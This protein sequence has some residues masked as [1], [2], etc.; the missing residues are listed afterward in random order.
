M[1]H[2][3]IQGGEQYL[4]FARSRITAM[5]AT[6]LRYASQKF[7]VDGTSI[8]VQ[9]V[10]EHEYIRLNGGDISILS[11]VVK[12]G[13]LVELPVPE[14]SPPG[15]TPVTTLR[16]FRA[17]PQCSQYAKGGSATVFHDMD[18]L[19]VEAHADMGISG[20]QYTDLCA[21]MYS[22][23]M[24]KVVQIIMGYGK[25]KGS[26]LTGV[27]VKYDFRWA[28]CHGVVTG[29][30]GKKWLLEISSANGVMAMRLPLSR[31]GST[32][33]K[34][35]VIKKTR[36]LL[37]GFPTGETFPVGAALTAAIAA[38]TVLQLLSVAG[39]SAVYGK[40]YYSTA[41]GWSF[42]D[43]GSEAHNT[44]FTVD[45]GIPRGPSA[46]NAVG[47]H[48]KLAITIG[49]VD[50]EWV[51]GTPQAAASATLSMVSSGPLAWYGEAPV[52]GVAPAVSA[53]TMYEPEG[54]T[55]NVL[56]G[57][58]V[59]EASSEGVA[60]K[61]T[62]A[63]TTVFVC[64]IANVL[65]KVRVASNIVLTG[66]WVYS[67]EFCSD[68]SN[69]S[70][71]GAERTTRLAG[72]YLKSNAYPSD[73]KVIHETRDFAFTYEGESITYEQ[74]GGLAPY[75]I[76]KY[77]QARGNRRTIATTI[78]TQTRGGVWPAF[79]RDC[80]AVFSAPTGTTTNTSHALVGRDLYAAG[81]YSITDVGSGNVDVQP[82]TGYASPGPCP[83]F[84]TAF[85]FPTGVMTLA[86][87]NAAFAT[88]A[89][90][91]TVYSP[92]AR[93]ASS[94]A[95]GTVYWALNVIPSHGPQI[96]HNYTYPTPPYW[97]NWSSRIFEYSELY[98]FHVSYSVFGDDYQITY[99]TDVNH[100]DV[101]VRA[102]SGSLLS[103]E[104]ASASKYSFTGYI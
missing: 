48:Y 59:S 47:Y 64:H 22:G 42:N 92:P 13:E 7:E 11:G 82:A 12:D 24:A 104:T 67:G 75:N 69:N 8:E 4:P 80:Y 96:T 29:A 56:P 45:N 23:T 66:D 55:L 81:G 26:P 27:Q 19:A 53:F 15:T 76:S 65:D 95:D 84:A 86:A 6:G 28:R 5:R 73:A 54:D 85:S 40:S 33:S 44:C 36:L 2:K 63:N 20:S 99:S 91:N 52:G 93:A 87:K 37:G 9:I 46:G 78:E 94:S 35:D 58:V 89:A 10:G 25:T 90:G 50:S 49:A 97:E 39:M 3:L 57:K 41:M 102:Y 70:P 61:A 32:S 100:P 18:R 83:N 1:E 74:Y 98:R 103:G 51:P 71:T 62:A 79:A 17:T 34:Q 72:F 43:A 31:S 60:L 14:G 21:S 16:S 77:V 38:G 68:I 88:L 30:D 101:S